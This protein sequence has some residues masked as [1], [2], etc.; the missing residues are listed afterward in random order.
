MTKKT[1]S[2]DKANSKKYAELQSQVSESVR[3][4]Q[5]L[6]IARNKL[7]D[8]LGRMKMQSAYGHAIL[9]FKTTDNFWETTIEYLVSSF[10]QPHA[11][12]YKLNASKSALIPIQSFGFN[13]HDLNHIKLDPQF[14]WKDKYRTF[15]ENEIT[16]LFSSL[17]FKDAYLCPL[18]NDT[19]CLSHLV[20]VGAD[21]EKLKFFPSILNIDYHSFRSFCQT[22]QILLQNQNLKETLGQ[23]VEERT[24]ELK[25]NAIELKQ[26]NKDL[27]QFINV[28][29]HDLK[30][31]LRQITSFSKLLF[32]RNQD[33]LD[34]KS[35]NYLEF[36]I[37][38]SNHLYSILEDL[39]KYS[40]VTAQKDEYEKIDFSALIKNIEH[41]LHSY[42]SRNKASI[43]IICEPSIIGNKFQIERVFQNL[44]ENAIKFK[45]EQEPIVEINCQ[46]K[47]DF[48]HITLTDNGIGIKPVYK[49]KVFDIFH[50]LEPKKYEGTGLGLAIV[51]KIIENHEGK[52]WI[53]DQSFI[54]TKFNILLPNQKRKTTS[55]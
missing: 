1:S 48:C 8:E 50:R 22:T 30:S 44:I 32:Q 41:S 9:Q 26:R 15:K 17:N 6:V 16:Q 53:D 55:T 29:S 38:G 28:A 34:D 25:T 19:S 18:Y 12:I 10:D 23:K 20:I 51:K 14:K 37:Q 13:A 27:E 4:Q 47:D 3:A 5:E 35:N 54:G 39:L 42:M 46:T 40:K 2:F 49:E 43:K 21:E 45:S 7:D 31:P 33:K 36:I 52:I 24:S 11:I